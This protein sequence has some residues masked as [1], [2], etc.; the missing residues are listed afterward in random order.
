MN[1][2][3]AA[4][5]RTFAPD[6]ASACMQDCAPSLEQGAEHGSPAPAMPINHAVATAEGARLLHGIISARGGGA[7]DVAAGV[8]ELVPEDRDAVMRAIHGE[9]GNAFAHEVEQAM[10]KPRH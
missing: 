10:A 1:V 8:V 5:L 3:S 6:V 9:H 7:H 2:H 4:G